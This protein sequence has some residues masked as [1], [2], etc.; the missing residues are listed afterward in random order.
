M[1]RK[2]I[3]L[4]I[5]MIGM[6]LFFGCGKKVDDHTGALP[7]RSEIADEYKWNLDDLYPD[8][9]KWD[10]EFKSVEDAIPVMKK[11][12]GILNK[13]GKTVLECLKKRDELAGRIDKLYVYANLALDSDRKSVV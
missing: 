11:Y 5:F 6:I 3:T 1:K 13:S 2:Q 8:P 9:E 10:V 7:E 12:T 4:F